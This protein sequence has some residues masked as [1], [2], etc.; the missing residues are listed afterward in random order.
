MSAV[1]TG[2]S[3]FPTT[4][5]APDTSFGSSGQVGFVTKLNSSGTGLVYSTLVGGTNG[6]EDDATLLGYQMG[7]IIA[8]DGNGDAFVTGMTTSSTFPTTANAYQTSLAGGRDAFVTEI[9]AAGTGFDYSTYLGGNND[10]RARPLPS[11]RPAM[12][13]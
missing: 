12:P 10:D 11:I 5:G 6:N 9:N 13:M 2:S 8:V 7:H 1:S 3:N 4:A